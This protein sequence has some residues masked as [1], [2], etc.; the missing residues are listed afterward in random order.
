[1]EDSRRSYGMAVM[2]TEHRLKKMVVTEDQNQTKMMEEKEAAHP[3][4]K[5]VDLEAVG[6]QVVKVEA[7]V[8]VRLKVVTV[9]EEADHLRVDSVQTLLLKGSDH[10][11]K[12]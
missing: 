5:T 10:L 12:I 1:M 8:P 11:V 9:V 7:K 2:G 3:Q 6:C 4:T